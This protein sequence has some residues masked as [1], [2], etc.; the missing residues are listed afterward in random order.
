MSLDKSDGHPGE[1]KLLLNGDWDDL[2]EA[3][4]ALQEMVSTGGWY[5]PSV[6][7]KEGLT[8][9]P[10][11]YDL[12]DIGKGLPLEKRYTVAELR[13]KVSIALNSW[14]PSKGDNDSFI[15]YFLERLEREEV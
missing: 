14:M 6:D 11:S 7:K 5:M 15:H 10:G 12:G 13:E 9:A 3:V 8:G 4:V 1:A 2:V